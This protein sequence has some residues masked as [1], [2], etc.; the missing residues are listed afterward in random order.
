[1][2]NIAQAYLCAGIVAQRNGNVHPSVAPSQVFDCADGKLMLAAGNDGQFRK[3]C[4]VMGESDI[5]G[6][7]RFC[8]QRRA[9]TQSRRAD[10]SP[11]KR[12][13]YAAGRSMDRAAGPRRRAERTDQRHRR[14]FCRS[15]GAASRNADR[16]PAPLGRACFR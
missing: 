8:H 13:C 5:A 1:M 10:N 7:A 12:I 3:L 4:E 15:S 6:D 14:S 9:R 16:S 11:A 2:I